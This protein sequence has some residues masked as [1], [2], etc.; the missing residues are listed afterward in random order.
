MAGAMMRA[1]TESSQPSSASAGKRAP[2]RRQSVRQRA[3]S[4][5]VLQ[6]GQRRRYHVPARL[7]GIAERPAVTIIQ[8]IPRRLRHIRIVAPSAALLPP[9]RACPGENCIMTLEAIGERRAARV[10]PSAEVLP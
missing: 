1:Q 4:P 3:S 10:A 6:H 2:A 9:A 5:R 8:R 7:Y